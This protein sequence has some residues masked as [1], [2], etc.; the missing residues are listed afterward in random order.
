MTKYRGLAA[1][2]SPNDRHMPCDIA[3][4]SAI[5]CIHFHQKRV[6]DRGQLNVGHVNTREPEPFRAN[7]KVKFAE[8]N[9]IGMFDPPQCPCPLEIAP[10]HRTFGH[11]QMCDNCRDFAGGHI[12]VTVRQ[13]HVAYPSPSSLASKPFTARDQ[14]ASLRSRVAALMAGLKRRSSR[15]LSANFDG[16]G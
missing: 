14:P 2:R 3:R 1:S 6:N 12:G 10:K 8:P 15:Q 7:A 11:L 4:R 9:E 5:E 13:E 16:S